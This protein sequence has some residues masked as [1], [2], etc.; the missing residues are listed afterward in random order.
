MGNI[1]K[2]LFQMKLLG[3]MLWLIIISSYHRRNIHGITITN[4]KSFSKQNQAQMGFSGMQCMKHQNYYCFFFYH[5]W[6]IFFP[7]IN[8]S[9]DIQIEYFYTAFELQQFLI[10]VKQW[11]KQPEQPSG[12]T[13]TITWGRAF[14]IYVVPKTSKLNLNWSSVKKLLLKEWT[15]FRS[16]LQPDAYSAAYASSN[17]LYYTSIIPK[18][19]NSMGITWRKHG[20]THGVFCV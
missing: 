5:L 1:N 18:T 14:T 2:K 7:V 4:L 19:R 20:P 15:I 12:A 9:A 11:Q 17:V 8:G 16:I 3:L 10:L 6:L 13:S